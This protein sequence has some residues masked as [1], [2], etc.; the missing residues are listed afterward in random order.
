MTG[1]PSL[2]L[3]V[4]SD[5]FAQLFLSGMRGDSLLAVEGIMQK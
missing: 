5:V 1:L 3:S 4:F 2:N